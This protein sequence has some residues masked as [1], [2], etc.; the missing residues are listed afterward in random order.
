MGVPPD[1]NNGGEMITMILTLA[2]V[3]TAG[4]LA[5]LRMFVM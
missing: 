5:L 2:L 3:A 1:P 4:I